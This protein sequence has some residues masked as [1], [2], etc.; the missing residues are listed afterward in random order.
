MLSVVICAVLLSS[1][2]PP[3]QGPAP[4]ATPVGL[5]T[6]VA[7]PT[8]EARPIQGGSDTRT[9]LHL[10]GILHHVDVA[11][12]PSQGWPAVVSVQT[13]KD[14]DANHRRIFARVYHPAAKTW[15]DARQVNLPPEDGNGYYGGVAVGITGDGVVHVTWGGAFTE[16]KPVW[17]SASSDYGRSWSAPRQI[18]ADCYN[19]QDM[20]TT[21]DGQIVVLALCTPGRH[22][23]QVWPGL[24]VRRA[25]GVWL[26]R[27]TIPI[28]GRWGSLVLTGDGSDARAVALLTNSENSRDAWIVQKR[29]ADPG[30]WQVQVKDLTPPAGYTA[31][32]ATFYLHRGLAFR[33]AN[34]TTG[35]IFTWAVYG[36]NAIYALTSLDGAQ[37]WGPIEAV[38]AHPDGQDH[39]SALADPLDARWSVPAYD[40]YADRLVVVWVGRDL[41]TPFPSIATHYASWSA[42]GSGEWQP[43]AIPGRYAPLVPL[44]TGA[45]RAAY[46]ASA[47]AGNASFFWLAWIDAYTTVKARTIDLNLIVPV[48]QYP[49]ATP[50]PAG[51]GA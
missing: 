51:G 15:G 3:A 21:L 45:E 8:R 49:T 50:R 19:V 28:D 13:W 32:E 14:G 11:V 9:L 10:P 4:A 34:G 38:V 37:S 25:D 35:V 23:V 5:P 1:C 41:Q 47:Q 31:R 44:V 2:A 43:F 24:I 36:G 20:A 17:Y 26:A 6:P 22:D 48:D 18:G 16:D 46:T 12:H 39:P 7:Y 29:L 33:R 27:D 30:P 42:P 40:G